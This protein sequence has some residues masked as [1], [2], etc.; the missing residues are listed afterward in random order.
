MAF[1]RLSASKSGACPTVQMKPCQTTGGTI[2][3]GLLQHD[4]VRRIDSLDLLDAQ[5]AI[6]KKS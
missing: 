1:S 4:A 5:G 2:L 6:A 3:D